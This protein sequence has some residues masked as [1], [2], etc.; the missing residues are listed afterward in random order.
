MRSFI[1]SLLAFLGLLQPVFVFAAVN[2]QQMLLTVRAIPDTSVRSVPRGGQRIPMLTLEFTNDRSPLL[3]VHSVRLHHEGLG[4]VKDIKSVYA[5][6]GNTRVSKATTVFTSDGEVRV[7]FTPSIKLVKGQSRTVTIALD[8]SADAAAGSEHRLVLR[9]PEDIDAGGTRVDLLSEKS[10]ISRIR[11]VPPVRGV[12]AVEYLKLPRPVQYGPNQTVA[13]IRLTADRVD[14]HWLREITLTNDGKA[15]N[16]DLQNLILQSSRGVPL[17]PTVASLTNDTVTFGLDTPVM[18]RKND[19]IVL[20]VK[21]DVLA[22]RTRTIRLIVEEP[23]DLRAD[24]AV[25]R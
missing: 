18:L 21:A 3:S 12:I 24:P 23:A 14:D 8:F 4:S 13:R 5:L 16:G 9:T 22:S 19:S 1:I 10:S 2:S 6:F 7:S 15:R 11:A 25:K 17:A 20:V